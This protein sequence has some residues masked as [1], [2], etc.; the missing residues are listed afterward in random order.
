MKRTLSAILVV[1]LCLALCACGASAPAPTPEPTPNPG[2]LLYNKYADIIDA[3]EAEDYDGAAEAIEALRPAPE[4]TEVEIT[5]D[6]LWDYFEIVEKRTEKTDAH[7]TVNFVWLSCVFTLKED[8][9]L[10]DG[11]RYPTDVAIGYEYTMK[12]KEYSLPCTIDFDAWT[13]DGGSA[14]ARDE[15]HESNMV[16]FST[17]P[18]NLYSINANYYKASHLVSENNAAHISTV[19]NFEILNASG[20][21]YLVNK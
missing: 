21:L 13:C 20:T 10:A 11:E 1:I 5:M 8:F 19:E 2:E 14:W 3:L 15:S 12:T 6:N 9:K 18:C 17:S 16:H 7:G 4:I